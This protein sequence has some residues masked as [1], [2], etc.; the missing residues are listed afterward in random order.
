MCLTMSNLDNYNFKS[1]VARDRFLLYLSGT[2]KKSMKTAGIDN[3]I[4]TVILLSTIA[5]SITNFTF[6]TF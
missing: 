2:R 5:I 4:I 1:L 3:N 6:F